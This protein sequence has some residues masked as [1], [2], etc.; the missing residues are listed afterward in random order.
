MTWR[1]G[2]I[3]ILIMLILQLAMA[4]PPNVVF[5]VN[6]ENHTPEITET[7][8]RDFYFK[9]KRYWSN[10]ESVRFMDRTMGPLRDSFLKKYIGQSKAEV[11]IFW[12]KQKLDSGDSAPLKVSS[13]ETT[14]N[15]VGSLRGAIGYVSDAAVL[16]KNVKV[17]KINRIGE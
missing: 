6:V 1:N 14:M 12:I 17:L 15:F 11:E 3:T 7:Q 13:D 5:I 9:H 16:R 4:R 8:L 10:G 2:L